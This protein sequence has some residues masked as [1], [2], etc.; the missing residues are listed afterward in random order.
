M[1]DSPQFINDE[2]ALEAQK[3]DLEDL[4]SKNNKNYV[5]LGKLI[6]LYL[7]GSKKD[8]NKA[9]KY[10]DEY[11]KYNPYE[12]DQLLL[13]Y[14]YYDAMNDTKKKKEYYEKVKAKYGD[15]FMLKIL[16]ASQEK[17]EK[18]KQKILEN[19][20]N[21][22]SDKKIRDM[23]RVSDEE[24]RG[25]KLTYYLSKSMLD[26]DKKEYAKAVSDYINNILG[27]KV[28]NE[29]L[30]YNFQKEMVL[31]FSILGIN[32]KLEDKM[33]MKENYKILDVSPIAKKVRAKMK[34]DNK[35]LEEFLK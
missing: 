3:K 12:Y 9:K 29:M 11:V 10:L 16:D 23:Y 24:Y 2:K 14:R 26:S 31:F 19:V 15:S 22:L 34:E 1:R 18:K 4:L 25:M 7:I 17:D 6:N 21:S 13:T 5:V 8:L 20:L 32:D 28:S 27:E 35:F 33:L 30:D